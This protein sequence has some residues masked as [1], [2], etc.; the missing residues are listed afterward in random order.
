MASREIGH[1]TYA[2][3]IVLTAIGASCTELEEAVIAL[4]IVSGNRAG[5]IMT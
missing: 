4:R 2:E 3:A 5:N 1:T